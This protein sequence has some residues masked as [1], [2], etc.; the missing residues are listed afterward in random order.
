MDKP[1]PPD[2]PPETD[3]SPCISLE[4]G[5]DGAIIEAAMNMESSELMVRGPGEGMA[6]EVDKS[7][8]LLVLRVRVE[9][10]PDESCPWG[11]LLGRSGLPPM[12][13]IA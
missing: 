3:D 2:P 4:A 9:A 5:A 11:E 13:P 8:I 12:P 7:S 1:S 6:S 10:T